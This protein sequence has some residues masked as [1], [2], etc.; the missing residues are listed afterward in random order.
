LNQKLVTG[1]ELA[2]KLVVIVSSFSSADNE[3]KKEKGT[4]RDDSKH[5]T[6]GIINRLIMNARRQQRGDS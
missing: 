5:S 2:N 3:K 6:S 1:I 4:Q